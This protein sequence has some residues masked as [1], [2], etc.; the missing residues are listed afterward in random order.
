MEEEELSSLCLSA[1]LRPQCFTLALTYTLLLQQQFH[2]FCSLPTLT[3]STSLHPTVET[4]ARPTG[5]LLRNLSLRPI[6][7]SSKLK[8]RHTTSQEAPPPQRSELQ[9]SRAPPPSFNVLTTATA[10][11]QPY[12]WDTLELHCPIQSILATCGYQ[13]HEIQLVQT[14][15]CCQYKIHTGFLIFSTKIRM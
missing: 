8:G 12:L 11:C 5:R 4:P 1:S 9:F 2:P 15:M 13:A 7:L 10:S 14:E 3:K 6:G